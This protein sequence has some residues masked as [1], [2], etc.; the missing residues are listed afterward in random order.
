MQT[1]SFCR[2]FLQFASVD[3]HC[4]CFLLSLLVKNANELQHLKRFNK[5]LKSTAFNKNSKQQILQ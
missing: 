1:Y 2:S 5:Q 3:L 4:Q